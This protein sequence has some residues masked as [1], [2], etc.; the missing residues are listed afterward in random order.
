MGSRLWV[1]GCESAGAQGSVILYDYFAKSPVEFG[2]SAPGEAV[3]DVAEAAGRLRQ[4]KKERK[5]KYKYM[6]VY[7][8]KDARGCFGVGLLCP[9]AHSANCYQTTGGCCLETPH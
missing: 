3:T 2:V 7:V 9:A 4:T 1:W 8:Y 5:K 6:D